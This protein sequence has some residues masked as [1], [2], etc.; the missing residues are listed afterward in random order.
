MR[1]PL[2]VVHGQL[3]TV[4]SHQQGIDLFHAARDPKQF[5]SIPWAGHKSLLHDRA[6]VNADLLEDLAARADSQR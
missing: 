1:C 6:E 4:V 3:D 5:I 2:T